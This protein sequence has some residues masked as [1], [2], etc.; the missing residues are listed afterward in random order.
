MVKGAGSIFFYLVSPF[1]GQIDPAPFTF[2]RQ[3][4]SA[5]APFSGTFQRG[6]FRA[7][8][9]VSPDFAETAPGAERQA[10]SARERANVS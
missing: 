8:L 3:H 10:A 4:L 6:T 7:G 9:I 1:P 5:A 2:Q